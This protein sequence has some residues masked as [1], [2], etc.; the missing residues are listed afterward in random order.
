MITYVRVARNEPSSQSNTHTKNKK[1]NIK[2]KIFFI[3]KSVELVWNS[4]RVN[5]ENTRTSRDD[6]TDPKYHI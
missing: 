2:L 3:L 4:F 1:Q 6:I 5:H